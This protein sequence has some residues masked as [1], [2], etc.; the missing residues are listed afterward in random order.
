[1][2]ALSILFKTRI[3]SFNLCKSPDRNTPDKA[4]FAVKKIFKKQNTS[5]H[6]SFSSN[7]HRKYLKNPACLCNG[8]L[9]TYVATYRFLI[10]FTS[11]LGFAECDVLLD[12]RRRADTALRCCLWSVGSIVETVAASAS[13]AERCYIQVLV[14]KIWTECCVKEDDRH[15]L[16]G[17]VTFQV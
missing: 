2:F 1:M 12:E 15:W 13:V 3:W 11:A 4:S 14:T 6:H 10:R 8:R 17:K 5:K 9:P 16:V 7:I